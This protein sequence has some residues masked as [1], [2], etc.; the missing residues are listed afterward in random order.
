MNRMPAYSSWQSA[1][2]Q[3]FWT[4]VARFDHIVQVYENDGILI[5]AVTGFV[6][7]A[8]HSN[9]NAV[10]VARH[11][12]LNALEDR[13]ESYGLNIEKLISQ[14][15]FIPLNVEEVVAE[16]IINGQVDEDN[17][18]KALSGVLV[19]AGSNGKK[20]RMFGEMS[21]YLF[22]QGHHEAAIKLERSGNDF[23]RT[24]PGLVY[25]AY[26]KKL[27]SGVLADY[28]IP[29]CC[30]HTKMISGSEKQLTH[31]HYRSIHHHHHAN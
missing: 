2:A 3:V 24:Y 30:A 8:I 28:S 26:P 14:H 6:E 11:R 27:F 21:T 10:I 17:M 20:F 25:C 16:F 1:N 15:K 19:N 9:E 12:Y 29:V 22:E 5:D 18:N 31:V 13:L 4:E 23:C 7:S